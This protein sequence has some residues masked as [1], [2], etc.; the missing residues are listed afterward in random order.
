MMIRGQDSEP[1]ELRPGI[2]V[3]EAARQAELEKWAWRRVR[4]LRAFYSHMTAYVI[5]NF[6]L[7]LI[8]LATPWPGMVDAPLTG[9]GLVLCLHALHAYEMLPWTTHDWEQRKVR[10]LIEFEVAPLIRGRSPPCIGRIQA[11]RSRPREPGSGTGPETESRT[12]VVNAGDAK[13]HRSEN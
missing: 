2:G 5:I 6:V 4:S 3:R 12:D 1:I 11:V 13:M 8:D 9:W 7:F 10:D